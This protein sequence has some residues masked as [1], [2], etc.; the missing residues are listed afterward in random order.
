MEVFH[1][2]ADVG[3]AFLRE[4]TGAVEVTVVG[5]MAEVGVCSGTE[6][7]E[8]RTRQGFEQ[9]LE[10]PGYGLETDGTM[11]AAVGGMGL[12]IAGADHEEGGFRVGSQLVGAVVQAVIGFR[13]AGMA[14][15]QVLVGYL[16]VVDVNVFHFHVCVLVKKYGLIIPYKGTE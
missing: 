11:V 14:A 1:Q 2:L 4:G 15:M 16:A 7:I 10:S 6:G 13:A 3:L 5:C 8:L 12:G 9:F